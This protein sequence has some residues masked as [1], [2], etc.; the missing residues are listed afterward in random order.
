MIKKISGIA[1]MLFLCTGGSSVA[2]N[3]FSSI[4]GLFQTHCTV[5][6]H[7]SADLSGNVDLTG[8]DQEVYNRLVNVDPTNPAAL[9][10][11][12][13]RIKPGYP[14]RSF[15]FRKCNNGLY[16]RDMIT[17]IDQGTQMP[18]YP[19]PSFSNQEVELIRQWIY[20]AAPLTGNVVDQ[21]VI[22]Q[23][24]TGGGI[25]SI[26]V[27]PAI[28]TDPAV[29]QLHLGK[30]FLAPQSEAEYFIKY[31]LQLPADVKVD[32]L[33]LIMAPQSHH[34][35]IYKL[36]PSGLSMFPEG[37]R[38]QNPTNG[39]GSS[40]GNNTLVNA[41]QISYDTR[42]PEGTS[43][44]W[45]AGS[46]LDLNYHMRN[47]SV[48]SVLGV[49]A[50][51]N[52]YT[53]PASSPDQ[54]M[55]SDLIS[56]PYFGLIIPNNSQPITFTHADVDPSATRNWNIWQMTSHTHK[57]GIDYDIFKRNADGTEGEQ[58]YEGFYNVD[59]SFNQGYYNFSHPPIRQFEPLVPVN[60]KNGLIQKATFKNTGPGWVFYGLTTAD[61]MMLYYVQYTLGDLVN[62]VE[63]FDQLGMKVYPN[64][65]NG[66]VNIQFNSQHNS[67]V[68][69]EIQD[70][71]GRNLFS[72]NYNA[73]SGKSDM[74]LDINQIAGKGM[75]ILRLTTGEGTSVRRI[76]VE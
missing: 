73:G 76:V 40:S 31:D 5:G 63:E 54:I 58:L 4:K 12:F 52:V 26:P 7:N 17:D 65:G 49:E 14:D 25:N 74:Q 6:C 1:L 24:Y 50:Y 72:K 57:Y 30:I 51:I 41:W 70:L 62:S 29:I 64:P 35:I 19:Q 2:Q 33:E 67:A 61:E 37:L 36:L 13:K 32:R 53:K 10:K 59:Y 75:F 39:S 16:P 15:L 60:P 22:N 66:I 28:S 11:G 34:F 47:Y 69:L 27:A 42:L 3:T 45:T 55:Y 46:V 68:K 38:L 43:Y 48:D 44:L 21:A 23:F 8:T 9:A 18:G 56:Y 71:A 20:K